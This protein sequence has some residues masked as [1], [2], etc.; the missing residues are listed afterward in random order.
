MNR[1]LSVT[2]TAAKPDLQTQTL[3][4]PSV[5]VP[6]A[7][8]VAEFS[9]PA[10]IAPPRGD[11]LPEL[12]CARLP[13]AV[14]TRIRT[15]DWGAPFETLVAG[16]AQAL[17][18][19]RGPNN[20]PCRTS[21]TSSGRG[22]V[23]LGYYDEQATA[24]ALQLGYELALLAFEPR[25][26]P[27]NSNLALV[28]KVVQLGAVLQARQPSVNERAM[29]RVARTR[30]IP[31]YRVVPGQIVWQYGQG[32]YGR[33]FLGTGSQRDSNTG[34]MLQDNK[35]ISNLLVRRLGFP[36]VEHG[37]ADTADNA[38]RLAD[39]MGYPVVIK[40]IDGRQG[41]GVTAGVT[42]KEEVVAAFAEANAVSPGRVIV[43]RF[44]E[45]ENVRLAVFGGRFAY[46]TS[47]SPPRLVGDG[48]HTVEELID[49]ENQHRAETAVEGLPKQLKVDPGMIATLRRQ[50]LQL[51]DRVL[52][53]QVFALRSVANTD[54][55][56]TA[57]LVTDRVHA[58]NREMA[59][60]IARCFRLDTVG[61]DF[62]TA[63]ITKCWRE[64]RCAVIEVNSSPSFSFADTQARSLLGRVF[65]GASTGRIPTAV[66]VSTEPARVKEVVP[67][68]QRGG[69]LVGFVQGVSGTLG[70]EPRAIAHA[71][72]ADRV[73][74]MLLDPDCE[75]LVVAC[76]PEEIM[77]HGFPLDR[78]DLCV[79]EIAS[80]IVEAIAGAF[81]TM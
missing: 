67:V 48:K 79:F 50:N 22:L 13:E 1:Q 52:A 10:T 76:T 77:E 68:L 29:I 5:F 45:G 49:R 32:K 74:A 66:V 55:G 58:D 18:D 19:W 51:N 28:A 46:A 81:G 4:G 12:I 38:V 72:L 8:V 27:V 36:G 64:V 6:F 30:E 61:I 78:C 21:R 62:L 16:L 54:A 47:R 59:E 23:Y 56:G 75:A 71:S 24:Q 69:V 31:F 35:M 3:Q 33:H 11:A 26:Q 25:R 44:V 42:S 63:D 20:L 40:P 7:A 60:A 2:A 73:Q 37:M 15:L 65:P 9:I 41:R 39:R 57:V 70:A 14:V 34:A 80:E 43:E 17:Q 53:G